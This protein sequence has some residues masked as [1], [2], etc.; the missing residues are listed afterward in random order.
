M[1]FNKIVIILSLVLVIINIGFFVRGIT[2]SDEINYYE[3]E[4]KILK[5][6]NT[7]YEQNIY[8]LESLSRTAS[9]AAE[10][11]FGKFSDP[12][13]SDSPQYAYNN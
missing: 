5:S 7:D 9:M 12:I 3:K 2:L 11:K 6:Q 13:F 4:L 10:M 1:N 8:T